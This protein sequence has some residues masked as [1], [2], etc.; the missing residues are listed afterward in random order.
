M[1]PVE[2]EQ[3]AFEDLRYEIREIID[4]I[5]NG[6]LAEI[7]QSQFGQQESKSLTYLSLS[8]WMLLRTHATNSSSGSEPSATA[9]W[10]IRFRQAKK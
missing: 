2:V 6:Y 10:L 5:W 1:S 4:A 8:S 3:Q 7:D 9:K